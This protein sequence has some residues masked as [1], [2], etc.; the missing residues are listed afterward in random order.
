MASIRD[1]AKEA[2]VSPATVS[3]VLSEDKRFSVRPATRE[4]VMNIVQKLH[5]DPRI[6]RKQIQAIPHKDKEIIVLT[7]LSSHQETRD[8]YFA[9]IDEGLHQEA[10]TSNIKIGAFVRFPNKQFEYHDV[11]KFDGVVIIGTFCEHFLNSVY[12]FNHNIVIVDEYRY[13]TKFDLVRNN[14]RD[15]T[16]RTLA[17]LYHQGYRRIAFIGGEVNQMDR[18]GLTEH[19]VSDIRTTE[20]LNWMSIHHLRPRNL[21]TDW[22]AKEGQLAM[23]ELLNDEKHPTAVMLASDQL[24]IGAYRAIQLH[25]LVIPDDI[26]VVSFNDSQVASYLVPSL[27]SVH[28]S[29]NEMGK[30]AIRLMIDRFINH[31]QLPC[32]LILPSTL[33]ARESTTNT[34][35]RD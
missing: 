26:A 18:K 5:Y 19:K 34:K 23:K 14:Y 2:G 9:S 35:E 33:I 12:Q 8:L 10:T 15:E 16:S 4:R 21:I 13:F 7:T 3:R 20:Y 29:S 25:H 31:R 22:S 32:Q 27:S 1:I 6:N 28:A 17:M 11:Q 30:A 24:A